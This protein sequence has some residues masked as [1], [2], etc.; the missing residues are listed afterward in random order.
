MITRQPSEAT[1]IFFPSRSWTFVIGLS[2]GRAKSK[3][4]FIT[5]SHTRTTGIPAS[6]LDSR[7]PGDGKPMSACF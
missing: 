4:C 6:I 5:I 7:T 2:S 3:T 1:A